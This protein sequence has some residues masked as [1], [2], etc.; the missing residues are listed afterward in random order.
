MS[1]IRHY[2]PSRLPVHAEF[3]PLAC[4]LGALALLLLLP[5]FAY[6]A[7]PE[8]KR[9]VWAA[10]SGQFAHI[11]ASHLALNLIGLWLVC[12]GFK[13]W[14][15]PW[16]DAL[17]VL[18]GLAGVASG[19]LLS[20][21][22]AWYRGLSGCLHGLFCGY[23]ALVLLTEN[24]WPVR[25]VAVT[26]LL[27]AGIKLLLEDPTFAVQLKGWLAFEAPQAVQKPVLYA[28]HRW[29]A[30]SGLLAG[31]VAGAWKLMTTKAQQSETA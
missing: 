28:A 23:A 27:G 6:V 14:R 15:T 26:L 29:G 20:P 1:R 19:L 25:A 30:V 3:V 2:N 22:I 4:T 9:Q 11:D 13:P 16:M 24:R 10:F 12:W 8:N 17:L 5:D 7:A 18:A 31:L 21:D